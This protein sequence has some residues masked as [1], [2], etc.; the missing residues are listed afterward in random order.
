[1]TIQTIGV[2]VVGATNRGGG[3]AAYYEENVSFVAN[4]SI[5]SIYIQAPVDGKL[6]AGAVQGS[7]TS[8]ATKTYTYVVTNVTTSKTMIVSTLFDADPVLT[9]GTKADLV[10]ST[11][12]VDVAVTKSDLLKIDF[13]GGTGSGLT[14]VLLTFEG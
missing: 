11:T 8:D 2:D 12:A 13:T 9:A 3:V 4:T 1:M 7:V 10:V 5:E 6:V 14:A